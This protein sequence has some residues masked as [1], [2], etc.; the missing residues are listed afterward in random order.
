MAST[1]TSILGFEIPSTSPLFL[2]IV[3]LHVVLGLTAVIA[4][5]VAMLSEKGMPRH[6]AFGRTYYWCLTA[7]FASASALAL[8]RWAEDYHLFVL[9]ALAFAA[10]TF[11]R[12]AAKR[13]WWNWPPLHIAGMGSSYV[14]MLTAFYV[15]NGK[16]LPLWR[17]LPSIAYWTVPAIVGAPIMIW[18]LLRHPVVR[19]YRSRR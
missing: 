17:Y 11:G 12:S 9:G 8:M 18:V 10:A 2:A 4:G 7:L 15:D 14:V 6:I 5:A 19:S 1:T 3:G 13:K 16:S